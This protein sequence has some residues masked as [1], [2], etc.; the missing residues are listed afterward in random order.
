MGSVQAFA[1]AVPSARK[2]FRSGSA[3]AADCTSPS[4]MHTL[5]FPL[6]P[7][8]PPA[9]G[10]DC[11]GTR[12]HLDWS[13]LDPQHL[14]QCLSHSCCRWVTQWCP[15]LPDPMDCSP[16]RLL[17]SWDSPGKSTGLSCPSPRDL[18][19]PGIEPRSCTTG[20]FF[21]AELPGKPHTF[22]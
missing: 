14:E 4:Q 8:G 10:Q 17:S 7:T 13:P 19:N 1:K 11:V 16:A 22:L 2:P 6:P 15:I 5:R 9:N 20:G 18:S 12:L 21:I 3:G